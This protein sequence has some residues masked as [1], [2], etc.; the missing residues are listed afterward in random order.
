MAGGQ[1]FPNGLGMTPEMIEAIRKQSAQ[2]Q[3]ASPMND[4]QLLA[5][6]AAQIVGQILSSATAVE[7]ANAAL[8][9]ATEIVSGAYA[10]IASGR[11]NKR[12]EA[13]AQLEKQVTA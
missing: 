7:T 8:D 4:V 2:L 10:R 11:V 3:I 9:L 12:L 1:G 5:L 13:A 6:V